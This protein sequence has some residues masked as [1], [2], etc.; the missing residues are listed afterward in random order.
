MSL[1]STHLYYYYNINNSMSFF[2][3]GIFYIGN[4]DV[5]I[6]GNCQ[7]HDDEKIK[8]DLQFINVIYY[9]H[10]PSYNTITSNSYEVVETLYFDNMEDAINLQQ[11]LKYWYKYHDHKCNKKFITYSYLRI[12]KLCDIV[13]YKSATLLD[14]IIYNKKLD[15]KDM[16]SIPF[17]Y[18]L[19]EKINN[20]YN[21]NIF[22]LAEFEFELEV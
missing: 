3:T 13:Q 7:Q 20:V 16:N 14:Y 5:F 19:R 9:N 11:M 1:P 2:K 18:E 4:N 10:C 15:M 21:K 6:M 12:D 17:S 8:L 22:N